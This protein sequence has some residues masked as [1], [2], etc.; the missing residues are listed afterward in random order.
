M[1]ESQGRLFRLGQKQAIN[2]TGR[3]AYTHGRARMQKWVTMALNKRV[4]GPHHFDR[5]LE[6][7]GQQT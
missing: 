7:L 5:T 1:V 2:S 6:R 3:D 4:S